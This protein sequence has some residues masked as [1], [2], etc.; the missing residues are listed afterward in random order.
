MNLLALA[1]KDKNSFAASRLQAKVPV[2]ELLRRIEINGDNDNGN[3]NGKN[4]DNIAVFAGD[5]GVRASLINFL[6]NV[7]LDT[8]LLEQKL[9]ESLEMW[10][11]LKAVAEE[12]KAIFDAAPAVDLLS[13]A[14]IDSDSNQQRA[15]F[16]SGATLLVSFFK[17]VFDEER[18]T[19][20]L[21]NVFDS[22]RITISSISFEVVCE[23]CSP[24][25]AESMRS[26]MKNVVGDYSVKENVGRKASIVGDANGSEDAPET[27]HTSKENVDLVFNMIDVDGNGYLSVKEV[28]EAIIGVN[29]GLDK[30]QVKAIMKKYDKDKDSQIS[31]VSVRSEPAFWKTRNI[32]EPQIKLTYYQFLACLSFDP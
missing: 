5:V 31:K 30:K 25:T 4:N 12:M 21:D 15:Y 32:S 26:V 9:G 10:A 23:R 17:L 18:M 19:P 2:K 13:N 14:V 7:Y 24:E 28:Q 29:A 22:I 3:G 16:E 27:V 11:G 1:A 6:N 20:Q 8:P